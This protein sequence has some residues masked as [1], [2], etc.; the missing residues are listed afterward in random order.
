MGDH[1][2][3]VHGIIVKERAKRRERIRMRMRVNEW[4][5]R[6]CYE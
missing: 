3:C 4:K 5:E 1:L 2:A 6:F